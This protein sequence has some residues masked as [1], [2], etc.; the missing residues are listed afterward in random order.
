MSMVVIPLLR[1][2]MPTYTTRW[3]IQLIG[4]FPF[5]GLPIVSQIGLGAVRQARAH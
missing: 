1:Q 5:V 4:H 2:Q 3:L